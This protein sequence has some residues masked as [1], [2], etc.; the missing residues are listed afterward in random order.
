MLY[1]K[2]EGKVN[3][4]IPSHGKCIT[5]LQAIVEFPQLSMLLIFSRDWKRPVLNNH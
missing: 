5:S 2:Q 3:T 1:T 4:I